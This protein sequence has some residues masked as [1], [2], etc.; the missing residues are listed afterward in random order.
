MLSERH[1]TERMTLIVAYLI[2]LP[3]K[4]TASRM[5]KLKPKDSIYN[6]TR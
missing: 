1:T 6:K 5:A 3:L 4:N 2:N